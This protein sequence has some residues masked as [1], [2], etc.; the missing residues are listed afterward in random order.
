VYS[1]LKAALRSVHE[2]DKVDGEVSGYYLAQE[3]P[4]VDP[5]MMMAIPAP[6]WEQQSRDMPVSQLAALLRDL[7][8]RVKLERLQEHPRKPTEKPAPK[9]RNDKLQLST[10]RLLDQNKRFR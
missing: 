3:L 8:A 10:A 1:V 7:P 6:Y 9:V 4:A 2:R 5:G